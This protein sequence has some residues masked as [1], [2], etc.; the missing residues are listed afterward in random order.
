[1]TAATFT[2]SMLGQAEHPT[3]TT[4]VPI[5]ALTRDLYRVFLASGAKEQP[6]ATQP[7]HVLLLGV[8]A[9]LFYATSR[10]GP[11]GTAPREERWLQHVGRASASTAPA[12]L[13]PSTDDW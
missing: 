6:G 7:Q 8:T 12:P 10:R 3:A 5:P 13:V 1:M 2:F 9:L 11:W 4:I